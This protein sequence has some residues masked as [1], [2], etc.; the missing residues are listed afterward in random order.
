MIMHDGIARSIGRRQRTTGDGAP[1]SPAALQ[2]HPQIPVKGLTHVV[3]QEMEVG[4]VCGG[5]HALLRKWWYAAY[6]YAHCSSLW[7]HRVHSSSSESCCTWPSPDWHSVLPA[8]RLRTPV[9]LV[10]TFAAAVE[11]LALPEAAGRTCAPV[12]GT[13]G[14]GTGPAVL[15][16]SSFGADWTPLAV[17]VFTEVF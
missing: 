9:G 1:A 2:S 5:V 17:E 4:A 14:G 10:V 3:Q 12:A 7:E 8:G 13:A 6:L 15:W 16:G 11:S